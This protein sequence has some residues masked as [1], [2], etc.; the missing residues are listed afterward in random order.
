[1]C[2]QARLVGGRKVKREERLIVDLAK[3]FLVKHLKLL[4][5]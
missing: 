5:K 3:E 4:E 2:E 1:M